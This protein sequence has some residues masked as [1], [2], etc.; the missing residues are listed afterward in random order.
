MARVTVFPSAAN[1]LTFRVAGDAA[2]LFEQLCARGVLVRDVSSYARPRELPPRFHRLARTERR[3]L[4][5]LA[6]VLR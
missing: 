6:E 3:V 5:A 2:E 1:F 4:D